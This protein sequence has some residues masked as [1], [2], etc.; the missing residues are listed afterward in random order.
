M[1]RFLYSCLLLSYLIPTGLWAQEA[2]PLSPSKAST[3]E[4]PGLPLLPPGSKVKGI[5]LPRYEN[6]RVSALLKIG[7][8]KVE[9]ASLVR[10][11]DFSAYLYDP[12]GNTTQITSPTGWFNFKTSHIS[13]SGQISIIDPRY[14][15]RG[16]QIHFDV[17][18]KLGLVRGP[19]R[20]V[21]QLE[22]KAE[23]AP[24]AAPT[25]K[26]TPSTH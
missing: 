26:S 11:D 22:A 24:K 5:L 8:L 3:T 12:E 7:T 10:V 21:I 6:N 4:F 9:E 23:K 15:L 2:S 19:V 18:R 14:R 13:S 17:T 25:T 1:F 16:Q 20:T